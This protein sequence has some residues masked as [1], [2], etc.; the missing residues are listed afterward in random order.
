MKH[1]FRYI[2][3]H[4]E[5]IIMAF[6]LALM[7]CLTFVQVVL[8]YVFNSGLVWSLETT[9]YAFGWLILLG[10]SYGVRT[11]AHISVDL[12]VKRLPSGLRNYIALFAVALCLLY[13]GL[14]VYGSS[15][16]ISELHELNNLARDIDLPKWLLTGIMPLAF[17]LLAVRFMQAG[18]EIFKNRNS[19]MGTTG[20]MDHG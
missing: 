18:L 12:F 1:N 9:T 19:S 17:V 7:T 10:M 13:S 4:I 3:N 6:L 14:M 16:Y 5:E 11:R 15:V 2:F 20:S 8:R